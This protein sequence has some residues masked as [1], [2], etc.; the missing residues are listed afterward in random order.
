MNDANEPIEAGGPA[1]AAGGTAG[2][3]HRGAHAAG[4]LVPA[5]I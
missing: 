4:S 3:A 1:R 5:D 2:G